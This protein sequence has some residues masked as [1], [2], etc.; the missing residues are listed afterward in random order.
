MSKANGTLAL[1]PNIQ[2]VVLDGMGVIFAAADDVAELLIPFVRSVGGDPTK[3]DSAYL[4]ASLGV[5]DAD[6]FWIRVGLDASLEAQYLSGHALIPGA[7]EFLVRAREAGIPVW[8]LSNDVARWSRILRETQGIETLLCGAIISSEA[9]ARKP[10][11]LIYERL[12]ERTG[13]RASDLL[14]IDDRPQNVE[15]ASRLGIRSVRFSKANGYAQ[16]AADIFGVG[17]QR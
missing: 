8:C 1:E 10:D 9:R 12:I 7:R 15:A 14:F 11:R 13:Y 4:D 6:E 16:L 17:L 2:C 5:I 3:V